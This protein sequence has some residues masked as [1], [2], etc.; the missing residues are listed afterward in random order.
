LHSETSLTWPTVRL[1]PVRIAGLILDLA[2]QA[3]GDFAANLSVRN[4][5]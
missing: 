4:R 1:R 3:G 2:D 5:V